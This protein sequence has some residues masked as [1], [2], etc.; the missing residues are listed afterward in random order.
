MMVHALFSAHLLARQVTPQMP[1]SRAIAE[2]PISTP[3]E[4]VANFEI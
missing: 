1:V 4:D 2:N 3:N